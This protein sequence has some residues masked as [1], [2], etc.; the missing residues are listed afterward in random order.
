MKRAIA[1]SAKKIAD[2][3]DLAVSPVSSAK[4]VTVSLGRL[5][6]T[7]NP[8]ASEISFSDN[9]SRILLIAILKNVGDSGPPWKIPF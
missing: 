3:T 7:S 9:E 2:S 5:G 6:S 8:W 1:F 4:L